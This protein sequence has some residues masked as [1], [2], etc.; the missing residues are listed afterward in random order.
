MQRALV[1]AI[2]GWLITGALF[3][4]F[5]LAQDEP[6]T[7]PII[8]SPTNGAVVTSPVTVI[9]GFKETSGVMRDEA[10]KSTTQG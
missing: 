4:S 9:V 5:A 6:K 8:L 3:V 2:A 7:T 10:T 1:S